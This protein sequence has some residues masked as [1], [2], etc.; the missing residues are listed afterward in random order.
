MAGVRIVISGYYG[1]SNAGDDAILEAS[2]PLIRSVHPD[3]KISVVTYPGADLDA[4]YRST[5]CA[6]VDGARISHVNQLIEAADLLLIGGGGLLQD[7]L[8]SDRTTIARPGH[9]NLTF[10]MSLAAMAR[11]HGV[12][13][14]T[15]FIGIGPLR[16]ELGRENASLVLEM[17]DVV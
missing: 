6:A 13:S 15:W 12:R 8:P 3:A 14:A 16:T 10:W 2:I 7:Y 4:V 17:I 5:G 9:N 1:F 11:A